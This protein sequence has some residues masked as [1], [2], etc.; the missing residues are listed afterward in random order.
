M[1]KIV[2]AVVALAL[3]IPTGFIGVGA[4]TGGQDSTD[5]G[6]PGAASPVVEDTRPAVDPA[7]QPAR[8]QLAMP[9]L[10]AAVDQQTPAGAEAA[11]RYLLD[12][13]PAMMTTGDTSA[14]EQVVSPQC[15]VCTQFLD[16]AQALSAQDG[17][18]VGGE[19]TVD[20]TRFS[21]TGEP[22]ASGTVEVRF[23]EAEGLLIDDPTR[24]GTPIPPVSGTLSAQVAWDG[25]RWRVRDMALAPDHQGAA[26]SDGGAG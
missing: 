21:G 9:P 19:F 23:R 25:S 14:W 22:P 13:Y 10:P 8:P 26:G 6:G 4:L 12:S 5:A 1:Q 11:V 17:Y 20:D 24:Q 16:N 3:I 18:L 15:A 2:I 7:D